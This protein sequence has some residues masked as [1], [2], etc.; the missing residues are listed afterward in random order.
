MSSIVHFQ[1]PS[2]QA[3]LRLENRAL[4]VGRTFACPDCHDT[5]LIEA[6]GSDG[7]TARKSRTDESTVIPTS[8]PLS[9]ARRGS[10]PTNAAKVADSGVDLR[11]PSSAWDR[12]SRRPAVLGW[13]VAALFAFIL[14]IVVNSG[15]DQGGP[16]SNPPVVAESKSPESP[17][18]DK[19]KPPESDEQNSKAVAKSDPPLPEADATPDA[20]KLEVPPPP[21]PV[22]AIPDPP[23]D[24]K[25][26]PQA[27]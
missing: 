6:K 25:P 19:S 22:D 9:A 24:D 17:P 13:I 8:K 5:L 12:L 23:R 27:V 3:P 4:F 15:H 11:M 26:V 16:A 2:C 1:C 14:L 20:P 10:G 7:V 18:K 21:S